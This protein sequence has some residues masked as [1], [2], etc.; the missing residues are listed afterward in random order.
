MRRCALRGFEE[1]LSVRYPIPVPRLAALAVGCVL[2]TACTAAGTPSPAPT[3]APTV[4]SSSAASAAP[5][6]ELPKPELTTV[7][8][9]TS[10]G[11]EISQF[12]GVQAVTLKLF[13]KHGITPTLNAFEGGAKSVGALLAGQIDIS[14]GGEP[15]SAM[16]SQMTDVPFVIVGMTAAILTD[17]L[18]CQSSI[19]TPADVKGA[20]V[21]ISSFGGV[22]HAS[23]LLAL[24]SIK[25]SVTDAQITVV[26]GQSA[27]IAAIKGG[28]VGCAVV[29]KVAQKEMLAAG[30]NVV[31]KT[32]DPPQPYGRA[33][34]SV[35]K[36]FLQKNPNT[37]LVAIAA[38]LEGQNL[39]WTDPDG[40][41]QRFAQH[42]QTDVTKARPQ[43]VDFQTVGNRS[44][45]W[46]DEAFINGKK[47]LA[48]VNPDIIDVD[49]STAQDKSLTQKLIDNGFYARIGNPATC[50]TWTPTNS[51]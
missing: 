38:I 17:D 24:K 34:I 41:A 18:I 8:L 10:A 12:A 48:S 45:L 25:L 46:T 16:A 15:G 50:Y 19:R 42:L 43:V 32:Y 3:A 33:N 35:T 28:S 11:G 21:A 44:L 40:T 47:I 22:S 29:D 20:K 7:R 9:G 37:V 14:M 39:I 27:R 1:D 5:K 13:E 30:L 4:A 23:A 6:G 2:V 51:C 31:A 26:G 36:A 49:I